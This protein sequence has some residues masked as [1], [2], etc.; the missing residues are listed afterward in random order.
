[1]RSA[2][3]CA[4]LLLCLFGCN[5]RE[6]P[7]SEAEVEKW[8]KVCANRLIA[9]A[10]VWYDGI[11]PGLSDKQFTVAVQAFLTTAGSLTTYRVVMDRQ[12][13][14]ADI[15]WNDAFWDAAGS[16]MPEPVMA[17]WKVYSV[18]VLDAVRVATGIATPNDWTDATATPV[19]T[20]LAA[21]S[22][23]PP[24]AAI[25]TLDR[26]IPLPDR[27][28]FTLRIRTLMPRFPDAA[29][30]PTAPSAE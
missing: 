12:G 17:E 24:E 14:P 13:F 30:F 9:E 28:P 27:K 19:V 22:G 20:T 1:V 29:M 11:E 16:V 26:L 4:A 2:L 10:R 18:D 21:T 8:S 5:S 15:T 7:S 3:C 6:L 23:M 25:A